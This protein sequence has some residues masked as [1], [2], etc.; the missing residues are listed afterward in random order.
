MTGILRAIIAVSLC[1]AAASAA[2]VDSVSG[3]MDFSSG[4]GDNAK[5][6]ARPLDGNISGLISEF[7]NAAGAARRLESDF[8]S[9]RWDIQRLARYEGQLYSAAEEIP[10]LSMD[11]QNAERKI[12]RLQDDMR[13]FARELKDLERRAVQSSELYSI[14][15][16]IDSDYDYMERRFEPEVYAPLRRLEAAVNAAKPGVVDAFAKPALQRAVWDLRDLERDLR[17]MRWTM[18]S[19]LSKTS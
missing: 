15:R 5:S 7:R 16:G 2:Q 13:R 11:V 8:N 6:C 18:R 17:D 12:S 9:L 4:M 14:A 10:F 3:F 1:S 19:I